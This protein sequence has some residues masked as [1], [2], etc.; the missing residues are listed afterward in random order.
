[1]TFWGKTIKEFKHTRVSFL[2]K[3]YGNTQRPLAT[4]AVQDETAWQLRITGEKQTCHCTQQWSFQTENKILSCCIEPHQLLSLASPWLLAPG[5]NWHLLGWMVVVLGDLPPCLKL[6]H[7]IDATMSMSKCFA[8]LENCLTPKGPSCGILR[9]FMVEIGS[10]DTLL[11]W[12]RKSHNSL[13][14]MMLSN[15]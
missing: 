4:A 1:M 2:P 7:Y 6:L 15:G 13:C 11:R 3:G 9:S 14:L 12:Q 10:D 8:D 5:T